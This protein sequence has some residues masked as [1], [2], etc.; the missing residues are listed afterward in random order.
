M[1]PKIYVYRGGK[2]V[3][4]AK[5]RQEMDARSAAP[6]DASLLE[7][8]DEEDAR[9]L[10]EYSMRSSRR[11]AISDKG[12]ASEAGEA[13]EAAAVV[14]AAE[15]LAAEEELHLAI[16]SLQAGQL[17]HDEFDRIWG[18]LKVASTEPEPEPEPEL[19]P[20]PETSAPTA[21]STACCPDSLRHAAGGCAS[22]TA[23]WSHSCRKTQCKAHTVTACAHRSDSRSSA[24]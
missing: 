23:D 9:R 1:A 3:R 7:L 16:G 21:A 2:R 4:L 20:E 17:T 15:A 24:Y 22:C 19:E 13:A 12:D 14:A 6:E 5:E 10:A 11:G 8:D 18:V